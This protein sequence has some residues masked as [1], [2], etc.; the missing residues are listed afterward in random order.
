MSRSGAVNAIGMPVCGGARGMQRLVHV[1][2]LEAF[3]E[4]EDAVVFV[5]VVVNLTIL[6][7][8]KMNVGDWNSPI[9]TRYQVSMISWMT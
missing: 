5:E 4:L 7:Y 9:L 2:D 1:R 6:V 8:L 3:E